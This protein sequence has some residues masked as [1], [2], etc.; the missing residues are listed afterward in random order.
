[1]E[2]AYRNECTL[3][4]VAFGVVTL[5]THIFPLYFLFPEI[6]Q[7][8]IFGFPLHYMLTM[9]IGWLVLIPLYWL[10]I[11]VSE[12]IDREIEQTSANA[13]DLEAAE[14]YAAKVAEGR[15]AE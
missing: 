2:K 8:V 3:A 12:K 14:Q 4:L 5:L 1:M 15:P 10:Y 6:T 11:E 7:Y 9:V 13:A